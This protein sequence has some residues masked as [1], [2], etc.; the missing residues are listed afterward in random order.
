MA[1]SRG[2]LVS[3][4]YQM[5]CPACRAACL[6]PATLPLWLVIRLSSRC[7]A[8]LP[9]ADVP[10]KVRHGLEVLACSRLE[11]VLAAAFD[12]PICLAPQPL[13]ARL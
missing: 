5:A 3:L 12:P 8:A 2:A 6:P 1:A 11:D 9:Q 4:R 10:A 7:V 13:L